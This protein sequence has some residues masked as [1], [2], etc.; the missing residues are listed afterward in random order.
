[1]PIT[2][3]SASTTTSAVYTSSGNS[4]VTFLSL[5][6][7][8]AGNVTANLYVVPS[9][10]SA[11]PSTQVLANIALTTLETYQLYAGGEKLLLSNGD[12]IQVNVSGNSAVTVVTSYTSV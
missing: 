12:T 1:M 4:A 11:G 3:S 10:G 5:C 2:T 6:N 8:S 7:Y 9:A